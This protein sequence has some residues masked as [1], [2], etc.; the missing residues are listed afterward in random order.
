MEADLELDDEIFQQSK[1]LNTNKPGKA[2]KVANKG[3]IFDSANHELAKTKKQHDEGQPETKE[4]K[5]Q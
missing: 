2:P 4:N 1:N 3:I 5:A